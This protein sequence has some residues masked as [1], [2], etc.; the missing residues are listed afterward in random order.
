MNG[1]DLIQILGKQ[2]VD[3]SFTPE[4][5]AYFNMYKQVTETFQKH[6]SQK[7]G[8]DG[9]VVLKEDRKNYI[10]HRSMSRNEMMIARNLTS[11]YILNNLQI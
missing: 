4:E 2:F 3:K 7:I 6:L 8:Q 10:P 5:V 11:D 9:E 1:I